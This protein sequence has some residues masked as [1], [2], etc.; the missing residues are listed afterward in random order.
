M[1]S[2]AQFKWSF[3]M[4]KYICIAMFCAV[5]FN[6]QALLLSTAGDTDS[7]V[8]GDEVTFTF[9]TLSS[10]IRAVNR[11]TFGANGIGFTVTQIGGKSINQDVPANGGLGV[12][13][14]DGASNFGDNIGGNEELTFS[15]NGLV[16][17]LGFTLNGKSGSNGHTDEAS[18]DFTLSVLTSP[19]GSLTADAGSFDGVGSDLA[20]NESFYSGINNF[21][22]F[23]SSLGQRDKWNGYVESITVRIASVPEPGT[24]ALLGLGLAGLGLSRRRKQA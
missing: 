21:S 22:F 8:S 7:S 20:L 4:K 2:V 13:D 24:L 23:A 12:D 3:L 17:L 19:G 9:D 10:D 15:F 14:E 16:D 6:T 11:L 5:S 18:G 1:R